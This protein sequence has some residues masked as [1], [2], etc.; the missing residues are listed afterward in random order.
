MSDVLGDL[1]D[2]RFGTGLKASVVQIFNASG[3]VSLQCG[4][5]ALAEAAGFRPPAEQFKLFVWI[6]SRCRL[7]DFFNR[8][9]VLK[10]TQRTDCAFSFYAPSPRHS[11]AG[12]SGG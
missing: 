9:H 5:L 2:I 7:F 12:R 1:D 8:A 4:K 11:G 3:D 10:I 6:E